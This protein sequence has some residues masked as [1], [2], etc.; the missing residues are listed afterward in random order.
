MLYRYL[1][2]RLE[3]IVKR[4]N[5]EVYSISTRL[6]RGVIFC[7]MLLICAAILYPVLYV[8]LGSFKTNLELLRGGSNPFP[9]VFIFSNYIDA[10]NQ[11][12]FAV[13]TKNS[14]LI[15]VSAMLITL[16][17]CSM[18][19]YVFARKDFRFKELIYST[20]IAFMFVNVGSVTLRPL[21]ELAV[22]V[23]LNQSLISVILISAGTG[24]ATYIFLVRGFMSSVPREIDEAA[25]IDG[26]TFFGIY[27]RIVLPLL[28]PVLATVALLSFRSGW[29]EYIMP[30][31]FT[32]TNDSLRPL[33]VGVA[34]LRNAGD[35]AAA[36]NIA[37]AGATLAIVPIVVLYIFT[38]RYF[39][40]G[41]VIGAVKG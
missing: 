35:G 19:G 36:W 29:N 14:V 21:F 17:C 39:M 18:A 26:C 2:G 5:H 23:G 16:L 8:I 9:E 40:D 31:V 7:F 12:N 10:W 34:M 15:S 22:A 20:F 3:F 13:Y 24:Q 27:V 41:M 6:S 33:T 28:K 32:M 4:K 25:K 1:C 37:F 30:L 11:A 38:S